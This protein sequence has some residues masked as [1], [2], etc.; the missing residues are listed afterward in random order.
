MP[1]TLEC[2]AEET[3]RNLL[4]FTVAYK[5]RR[6]AKNV[7]VIVQAREA[8][9][10]FIPADRGADI[11]M[12]VRCNRYAVTASAEEDPKTVCIT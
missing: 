10:F 11:G 8:R 12:F 4:G 7:R 3:A 9:K 1:A 5:A 6:N 2:S